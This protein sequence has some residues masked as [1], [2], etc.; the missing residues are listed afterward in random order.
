MAKI[1]KQIRLSKKYH[2]CICDEYSF[3]IDWNSTELVDINFDTPDVYIPEGR[4]MWL[5]STCRNCRK[6]ILHGRLLCDPRITGKRLIFEAMRTGTINLPYRQQI[7]MAH[8]I[9]QLWEEYNNTLYQHDI[10]ACLRTC[11]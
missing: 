5:V 11:S 8:K 10:Q 9:R 3:C 2:T 4:T 6:K 1:K 7:N